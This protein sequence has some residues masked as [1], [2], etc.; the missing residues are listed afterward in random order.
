MSPERYLVGGRKPTKGK[1]KPHEEHPSKGN[2]ASGESGASW[3]LCACGNPGAVCCGSEG[4]TETMSWSDRRSLKRG[5]QEDDVE[6][7]RET[8][9]CFPG[10]MEV[11]PAAMWEPQCAAAL[12]GEQASLS[13]RTELKC[14]AP[15]LLGTCVC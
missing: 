4:G 14:Q 6:Q 15:A 8:E 2:E 5:K 1:E 11:A 9:A 13:L 12:L 3:G 10:G 7:S